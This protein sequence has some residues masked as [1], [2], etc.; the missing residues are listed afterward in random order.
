VPRTGKQ[1]QCDEEDD[2]DDE[3]SYG[4][5]PLQRWEGIHGFAGHEDDTDH[6]DPKQP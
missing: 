6:R 3:V 4:G 5:I 1:K 2:T